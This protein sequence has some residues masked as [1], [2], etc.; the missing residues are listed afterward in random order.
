MM[1]WKAALLPHGWI[2]LV[3][4]PAGFDSEGRPAVSTR[5][6]GTELL[7]GHSEEPGSAGF[8]AG[9]PWSGWCWGA[10]SAKSQRK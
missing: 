2:S 4:V 3:S 9:V 7:R 6:I 10:D 1:G 5:Q 8:S